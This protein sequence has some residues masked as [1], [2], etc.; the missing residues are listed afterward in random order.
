MLEKF[1][2][3]WLELL[4]VTLT[5]PVD[6]GGVGIFGTVTGSILVFNFRKVELLFSVTR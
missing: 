4:M 6:V 3:Y 2:G 5:V 1:V